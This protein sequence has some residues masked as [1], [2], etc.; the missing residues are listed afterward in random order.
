[1]PRIVTALPSSSVAV[2]GELKGSSK[3]ARAILTR[4][5]GCPGEEAVAPDAVFSVGAFS[6]TGVFPADSRSVSGAAGGGHSFF[7]AANSAVSPQGFC[8]VAGDE[9]YSSGSVSD[10]GLFSVLND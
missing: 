9:R 7:P 3:R 1:M 10:S 8:S 2:T 6:A 5:A 4:I